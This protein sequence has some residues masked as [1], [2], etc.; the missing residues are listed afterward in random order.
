MHQ[1]LTK[2]NS[3][4]YL[5]YGGISRVG[6]HHLSNL[7]E[8]HASKKAKCALILVTS[9]GDPAAGYRIARSLRHHYD[10]VDVIIP[11]LCKSAGT[12]VC[13]GAD[14]LIFGDRGELGPLDM[15]ISKPDE[16]FESMSGLDLIQALAALEG[17][18]LSSFRNYLMD[19]RN[20]S[21]LRTK[22]AADI[23]TKLTEDFIAPIAAKIDPVTL[24][25]H[26]RAMQIGY[27]YGN[28]LNAMSNNLKGDALQR[29]VSDYASH[30]FVIDRKEAKELFNCVD[31]PDDVTAQIIKWARSVI[32]KRSMPESPIII[33]LVKFFEDKESENKSNESA[34]CSFDTAEQGKPNTDA[35]PVTEGSGDKPA[36][37]APDPEITKD[38]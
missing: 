20:G 13:I 25:E 33:D 23:A 38:A 6:Y 32:E 14:R 11:D 3:D 7:L 35:P 19:I 15:Q 37:G 18:V 34:T 12:L 1:L 8:A 2:Y 21:G 10:S 9:G 31:R 5:Y 36:S 30:G 29:L 24:G 22:M 4:V 26:Q 17:R 28:R 27:D 16:L